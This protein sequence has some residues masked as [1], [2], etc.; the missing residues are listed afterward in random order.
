MRTCG[1]Q[2]WIVGW[3]NLSGRAWPRWTQRHLQAC[4]HCRNWWHAQRSLEAQ[5]SVGRP[6]PETSAGF[7]SGVMK[8][9][10][11]GEELRPVPAIHSWKLATAGMVAGM[12]LLIVA[13]KIMR[14]AS[15]RVEMPESLQFTEMR[16]LVKKNA[17]TLQQLPAKV[18]DPLE[19]ELAFMISDTRNAWAFVAD[20]V[21]P[22][23]FRQR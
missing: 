11:Q 19:K 12:A 13:G 8:R 6:E 16:L 9:I 4:T 22:N 2:R 21:V 3:H 18:D 1:I 5:L 23:E 14:E 7:T 15:P 20:S 10:E 17:E